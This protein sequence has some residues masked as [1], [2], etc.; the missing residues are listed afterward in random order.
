MIFVKCNC[1]IFKLKCMYCTWIG[2][3]KTELNVIVLFF[4]KQYIFSLDIKFQKPLSKIQLRDSVDFSRR[5]CIAL[6]N[7][8]SRETALF[9]W[10]FLSIATVRTMIGSIH[11]ISYIWLCIFARVFFFCESPI[12][13]VDEDRANLTNSKGR[14]R[15]TSVSILEFST[16]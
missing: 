16:G 3:Y 2:F 9:P 11:I 6:R 10:F 15:G 5:C 4:A 14:P 7:V 8:I 12:V 1:G 13:I